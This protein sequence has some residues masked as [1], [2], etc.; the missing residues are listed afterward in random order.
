MLTAVTAEQSTEG[1]SI[2]G[3]SCFNF[4]RL[5][6]PAPIFVVTVVSLL[7]DL[8]G[9]EILAVYFEWNFIRKSADTCD[10]H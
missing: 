9:V 2:A 10:C 3:C 5:D 4:G 1:S 6:M 8:Q 7:G